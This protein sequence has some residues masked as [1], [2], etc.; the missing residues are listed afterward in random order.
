MTSDWTLRSTGWTATESDQLPDGMVRI[1]VSSQLAD[2]DTGRRSAR[3]DGSSFCGE[4]IAVAESTTRLRP[5]DAVAGFSPLGATLTMP[6]TAVCPVPSGLARERAALLPLLSVAA[7]AVRLARPRE[8]THAVVLGQ[9]TFAEIVALALRATGV[10]FVVVSM[11]VPDSHSDGTPASIAAEPDIA[12][13]TSG[14]PALVLQL[15]ERAARLARVVL[16]GSPRG[17]AVDVD[18]YRTV[19]Q[20]GLEVIGVSDDGPLAPDAAPADRAHDLA[21]ARQLLD[22]RGE[23]IIGRLVVHS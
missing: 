2:K 20:R 14:D 22:T 16:A 18:L 8:G 19:H 5:G 23:D 10:P 17:R 21:Q 15:F 3:E 6:P 11:S 1:R 13:D 7:R 9:G 4:V 12:I